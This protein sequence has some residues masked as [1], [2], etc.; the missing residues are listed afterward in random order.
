MLFPKLPRNFLELLENILHNF[1]LSLIKYLRKSPSR[2][3]NR[4]FAK[5]F[6]WVQNLS[7]NL[8][9][10]EIFIKF[11]YSIFYSLLRN[12]PLIALRLIKLLLQNVMKIFAILSNITW[13]K[14]HRVIPIFLQ[15][16]I[17]I[18]L[19]YAKSPSFLIPQV[20][21]KSILFPPYWI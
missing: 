16:D 15:N 18:F 13:Q 14:L 9:F 17:N 3:K 5:Y 4:L 19:K 8:H 21:W 12:L 7:E 1:L 2:H 11:L 20:F 10:F 6:P